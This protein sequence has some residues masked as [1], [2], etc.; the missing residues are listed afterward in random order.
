MVSSNFPG[1]SDRR[2]KT[3]RYKRP[4]GWTQREGAARE[5]G[6]HVFDF[7]ATLDKYLLQDKHTC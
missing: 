2:L 1:S 5:G 3:A 6:P 4:L 7:G